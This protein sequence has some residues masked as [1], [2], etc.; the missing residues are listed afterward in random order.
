MPQP[1]TLFEKIWDDHVILVNEAGETLLYVGRALL[2][3]SANHAFDQLRQEGR[4]VRRPGQLLASPDH[5]VP[6]LGRARGIANPEYRQQVEALEASSRAAGI[7][8]FGLLDPRQGILQVVAPEQGMSLPG[9]VICGGDSHT[10]TNG[11][12]GCLAFGIGTSEVAH[13]LATQTIWL[14]KPKSMR[15]RVEGR[16][17]FGVAAKDVILALIAK[18]SAAGGVGHVVEYAGSV[19]R[20][21]SM[22]ER[23]TVCNM[24]IEFGARTG[25]VAPDETTFRYVEG[26]PFAPKG[27]QWEKALR[28]WRAL[29]SDP[30]ARFDRE[31][32]LEG[33]EIAPM[34]TWG[35][36]PETAVPITARV[37]D[38]AGEPDPGKRADMERALK[39]MALQPGT[40]LAGL[41]IDRVFIG[42]C[43]NSRI[44]DLRAA[45]DVAGRGK[46]RVSA[47]VVPGSGLVKRQAEAEGLDRVFRAAGFEW[48]EPSCSACT[49]SID[50]IGPGERCASTINRNFED[51]MG[52]G[53]RVHL[54]SPAMAAAAALA[55]ALTDVRTLGENR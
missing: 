27:A 40:A 36:N 4:P 8:H 18:V 54:V 16:R 23:L 21:M 24:S 29:P 51:R 25:T 55:G 39:Y 35:T 20:A 12:L 17:G 2:H 7:T 5:Y 44:E 49:G 1:R 15:V 6:T 34:V 48:R 53:G 22:E 10:G 13:V 26:R 46:A 14:R 42:S 38:P 43:T 31:V 30:D 9:L 37:P 28:D 41:P 32:A 11:A 33:G 52:R 19:V 3:D 45:A 50:S 47:W